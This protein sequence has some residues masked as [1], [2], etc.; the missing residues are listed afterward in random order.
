VKKATKRELIVVATVISRMI[1]TSVFS[2]RTRFPVSAGSTGRDEGKAGRFFL[3]QLGITRVR[4]LERNVVNSVPRI[5][6]WQEG[7]VDRTK[8]HFELRYGSAE[9]SDWSEWIPV[10]VVGPPIA[11]IVNV[12]FLVEPC[13]PRNADVV[14]D[15]KKEIQFYL[16]ELRERD[17]W[18]YAQYHCG[19]CANA[20]SEVHWSFFKPE[21][22]IQV[23]GAAEMKSTTG[24]RAALTR[25]RRA[26]AKKAAATRKR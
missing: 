11:G 25:K 17:P 15:V 1:G 16:F 13:D 8:E 23:R 22:R 12:Q 18:R 19:T 7:R 20:H 4:L 21:N 5:S 10:A 26:A 6:R 9:D 3:A 14:I 24:K 2:D